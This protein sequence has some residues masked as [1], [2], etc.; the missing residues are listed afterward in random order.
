MVSNTPL[1]RRRIWKTIAGILIASPFPT[2]VAASDETGVTTDNS[3]SPVPAKAPQSNRRSPTCQHPTKTVDEESKQATAASTGVYDGTV[4]RI[5]DG[6]HV[7]IL[8]ASGGE[9]IGQYVEPKADYPGLEEGDAVTA[10]LFR[11]TLV[12]I[13]P[14]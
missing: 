6:D 13:W 3:Q 14:S 11:G 4:D 7:V 8:I 1:S 5:V 2:T 10:L 9:T 12:H